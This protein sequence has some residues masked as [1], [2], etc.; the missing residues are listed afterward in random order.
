MPAF[1][2]RAFELRMAELSEENGRPL[3]FGKFVEMLGD[4]DKKVAGLYKV[5]KQQ[6]EE[7]K[8]QQPDE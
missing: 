5:A 6:L 3:G 1:K 4:N 7:E 8:K 2:K